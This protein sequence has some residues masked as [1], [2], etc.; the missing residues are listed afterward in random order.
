MPCHHNLETY[1]LAYIEGS[2][3][4]AEDSKGPSFRTIGRSKGRPLTR[5]AMQQAEAHLMT[6]R[7]RTAAG[8][9]TKLGNRSFRA[10][11]ITAYLKNAGTQG[12]ADGEPCQHTH[13]ATRSWARGSQP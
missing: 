8:I 1:L 3:G 5:T 13:D 10:T 12:G 6:D 2:A 9:Q 7:R 4:I 11:G